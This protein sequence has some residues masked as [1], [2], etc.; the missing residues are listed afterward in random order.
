MKESNDLVAEDVFQNGI[1]IPEYVKGKKTRLP[2]KTC[3]R[4]QLQETTAATQRVRQQ[5]EPQ[6]ATAQN[7]LQQQ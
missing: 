3:P 5:Q 7:V 2:R 6:V 1:A 4:R